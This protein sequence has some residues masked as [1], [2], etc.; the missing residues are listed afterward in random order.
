M[1]ISQYAKSYNLFMGLVVEISY[2]EMLLDE[3]LLR[4]S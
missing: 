4:K 3:F 2:L 1:H